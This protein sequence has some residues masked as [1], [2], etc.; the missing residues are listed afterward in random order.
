YIDAYE[1]SDFAGSRKINERLS[2]LKF[3]QDTL[4]KLHKTLLIVF[5]PSKDLYRPENLP[6]GT[7]KGD[8]TNYEVSIKT[9]KEIGLNFID[10]EKCFREKKNKSQYPLYCKYGSHWSDYG[11]CFAGD[12]IIT[13]IEYLRNIKMP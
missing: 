3:L 4:A 7:R 8:S 10:F 6:E 11:A 13:M 5:A 1:G 9:S 12:S 2:E